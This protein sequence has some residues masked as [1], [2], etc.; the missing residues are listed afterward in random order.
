MADDADKGTSVWYRVPTWDGSP[1]TWRAFKREMAWWT[2]SLNLEDTKKYNIAARWLLRQTGAV[3]ARGEEFDPSDLTYQKAVIGIDPQTDEEIELVAEDPLAGLNKL[4]KAL[5]S[6]NGKTEL[7]RRGELRGS[8]YLELKRKPGERLSE[9]CTRFRTMVAEMRQ[10]GIILPEGELGWFLKSKLGLDQ[11]RQQ[12]LET[13]LGGKESYDAVEVEVLR[14]FKDLHT[15]DPLHQRRGFQDHQNKPPLLQRFLAQGAGSTMSSSRTSMPMSSGSSWASGPRSVRSNS[16]ASSGHRPPFRRPFQQQQQRQSNVTEIDEEDE[17]V[18]EEGDGGDDGG[19]HQAYSLEEVLQ[20]EAEDLANEL[21]QAEK[22]G[23]DAELLTDLESGVEQAA[24]SLIT[25]REARGKLAEVRKDRGYGKAPSSTSS[26]PGKGRPHGN[27]ATARK[28]SGKHPCW[29][30]LQHGHWAGDPQ[31]PKPGAGL[32]KKDGGKGGRHVK[33]VESLNTEHVAEGHEVSVAE[34]ATGSGLA[35]VLLGPQQVHEVAAVQLDRG[36]SLDEVLKGEQGVYAE[37][38]SA[39][40]PSLAWDKKLVGALDSA[41]S[42]TC[43]GT[44]WLANYLKTLRGAPQEIQA[45][46]CHEAENETFRFGNGGIQKSM[47]RWRLP[48]MIGNQLI[49][50]WT[51]VVPV[52]SL[53]LLLGRDFLGAVGAVLSFARRALRCDHLDSSVII[54]L[55]QLT[56]GHFMLPLIPSA[57]SR[58][59]AQRWRCFGQDGVLELQV[60]GKEWVTRRLAAQGLVSRSD[61]MHEHLVTEQSILAA[62]VEFSGLSAEAGGPVDTM[63]QESMR[64]AEF[65]ATSKSPT[66]RASGGD[67]IKRSSSTSLRPSI[68]MRSKVD[69]N[70]G[71]SSRSSNLARFWS[72]LVACAATLNSIPAVPISHGGKHF[73]LESP[74]TKH[75]GK[76]SSISSTLSTSTPQQGLHGGEPSGLLPSTRSH[77]CEA[78]LPGGS[79]FGWNDGSKS[80][81]RN[82]QPNQETSCFGGKERSPDDDRWSSARSRSPRVGWTKRRTA[83]VEEGPHEVGQFGQRGVRREDHSGSAEGK[84]Q[85]SDRR[86]ERNVEQSSKKF[87]D[88]WFLLSRALRGGNTKEDTRSSSGGI[89]NTYPH[90]SSGSV[91]SKLTNDRWRSIGRAGRSNDGEPGG[92]VPDNAEPSVSA[93]D[94]LSADP[95]TTRDCSDGRG[96]GGRFHQGR[97]CPDEPGSP[98]LP[99]E[100]RVYRQGVHL[101]LDGADD[102]G[103]DGGQWKLHQKIKPGQQKLISQAWDRHVADRKKTSTTR[104]QLNKVFQTM[105]AKEVDGFMNE[106]FLASV[107]MPSLKKPLVGEVYTHSQRVLQE[108]QRRGHNVGP[109]MSLEN[110]WNFLNAEDRRRARQWVRENEPFMLVLAFPCNFWTQLLELNPPKDAEGHFRRGLVL[111][112][113]ALELAEE[114]VK[115][116]RHYMLENPAGSRA[117]KLE[118]VKRWLRKYEALMVKFDQCQFGLRCLESGLLHMKPT[119]VA[120]SSQ[121]LVS[122]FLDKRC[123]RNHLHA[124]VIGGSKITSPAGRYPPKMASAI[125]QG[126]EEQFEF[127]VRHRGGSWANEAYALDEVDDDQGDL[128]DDLDRAIEGEPPGP[129]QGEGGFEYI[130]DESGSDVEV[131]GDLQVSSGVLQAVKRLHENTGHRSRR[132]LAR[133]LAI[134]G[135]P[136]EAIVAAKKLKC[137]VCD[138]RKRAKPPKPA[139]LP[140][141]KD[142]NDQVHIDLF[143]VYDTAETKYTVVHM[144][145]FSSRYQMAAML[146][147]KATAEVIGFIKQHWLPLLGPPRVLVCDHG[148]EFVSHEFETFCA[149]LGIYVYFTGIGAPWQNGVAERSGGSLKAVLGAVV[150]SHSV[151]GMNEM[152]NSLGEATMAY[153]MDVG[154]SGFS[155]LQVVTGRQPRLQGDVLGGIQQRLSEHSLISSSTS[156][157]RSLAMR[158]TAKLAM[159]RLHFS[160]GLRR[161]EMARSRTTTLTTRPEAGDIVYFFRDQ[162]YRG[163][164]AKRV[165]ALR[166]WHGPCLLVAY[167]GDNNCFVSH[168]G[169]LVKCSVEQVRKASSLEQISAGAWEEAIKECIDAALRDQQPPPQPQPGESQQQQPEGPSI[170]PQPVAGQSQPQLQPDLSPQL[171]LGSQDGGLGLAS[172]D[173]SVPAAGLDLPPVGAKELVTAG[174]RAGLALSAP[175]S[176]I[177]GSALTSRRTSTLPAQSRR[178]SFADELTQRMRTSR[179]ETAIGRAREVDRGTKRAAEVGAEDFQRQA[180]LDTQFEEVSGPASPAFG[181]SSTAE[182]LLHE[183]FEVNREKLV[184]WASGKTEQHPLR[185]IQAMAALDRLDPEMCEVRDHGSWKGQ[186]QLPSRTQWERREALSLTWPIGQEDYEALSVQA[187]RKEYPWSTMSTFQKDEFRQACDSGWS[188]WSDNEAVEILTPLDSKKVID[189]LKRR[190]EMAKLLRPRWVFTDKHDG[191][192]TESRAVGW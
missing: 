151:I 130:H 109:P 103:R 163:R 153:N 179:L 122:K 88:K 145:D 126:A 113:F 131:P 60:S 117:W 10:E 178:S 115:N 26:S 1:A 147:T 42:R 49:L 176:E 55:R 51:S 174:A 137:S 107:T 171:A 173:P 40:G 100:N 63:V 124:Q 89:L 93:C 191:L 108:A 19:D 183:A 119:L 186:W 94:E 97:D 18:G 57:W 31:C 156:M 165:L 110:G 164:Q 112:R 82:E 30:C 77:G 35:S 83:I 79:N 29:D 69:K 65:V 101:G 192:R 160:K 168:K 85:A 99:E 142:V 157:A 84:D 76:W 36:C 71:S 21:D 170:Q 22:E 138:E 135:A 70:G 149:G 121:A 91:G 7:D 53:G 123:K 45:L 102:P 23:L 185:Q 161:A 154:D 15:A 14:L 158:E 81:Q 58:P 180:Q 59:G 140:V 2:S 182:A 50:F 87:K 143:H 118:E 128:E 47:E 74:S 141:P 132:R 43:T 16:T 6:L 9:F 39:N 172:E 41:C 56:A 106:I 184:E 24:E 67:G 133:A 125:V 159:T 78:C 37:V 3:R 52:P 167:E 73:G 90:G 62:D 114:Q 20:A 46:V 66:T 92:K 189:D 13:A 187:S 162:K 96:T 152:K 148:R 177:Q 169:Q 75:G 104:Q 64:I 80:F 150:A 175:E 111:L 11:L 139:S 48:T 8:F 166:R 61:R 44:T 72:A 54:P 116:G 27:Q 136:P 188:V 4:L 25:M 146:E 105:W 12:L 190:G 34:V 134:S 144:T 98:G 33:V 38:N 120:T 129:Q 181:A 32:G 28:Q 17:W 86:Y 5:E 155:P 127:D 68:K 95:A